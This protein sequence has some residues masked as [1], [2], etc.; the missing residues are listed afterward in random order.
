[1]AHSLAHQA[2]ANLKRMSQLSLRAIASDQATSN[3]KPTTLYVVVCAE[4]RDDSDIYMF[5]IDKCYTT[6]EQANARVDLL[7]QCNVHERRTNEEKITTIDHASDG[8]TVKWQ[9]YRSRARF[10]ASVNKVILTGNVN[11][12]TS[13]DTSQGPGSD[14]SISTS[15]LFATDDLD[16]DAHI[17]IVVVHTPVFA[18]HGIPVSRPY[19]HQ[20]HRSG[21]ILRSKESKESSLAAMKQR[22]SVPD[23]RL[24]AEQ[25]T[26]GTGWVVDSIHVDS[27]KALARAK[28]IWSEQ[29]R[30]QGPYKKAREHYGFARYGFRPAHF[31]KEAHGYEDCAQIRVERVGVLPVDDK[32]EYHDAPCP[33]NNK[34]FIAPLRT[35]NG[36]LIS[37]TDGYRT[38]FIDDMERIA[39][40]WF[41]SEE[42]TRA[43]EGE[44]KDP[45]L[46]SAKFEKLD[47]ALGH[48]DDMGSRERRSASAA[49]PDPR[50]RDAAVA[51]DDVVEEAEMRALEMPARMLRR[52]PSRAQLR[53]V[54]LS[55]PRKDSVMG[56]EMPVLR[57]AALMMVK[58]EPFG[59]LWF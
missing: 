38:S 39:D 26:I 27:D 40:D 44:R 13:G 37:T 22:S 23:V 18:R 4:M 24:A 12:K 42:V 30:D 55:A 11:N 7:V 54:E 20:D 6:V 35:I 57:V 29:F 19:S 21:V 50:A 2:V 31:A 28:K 3:T 51:G 14:L 1:M 10:I 36:E 5:S 43:S 56:L 33:D 46:T 8:K 17:W 58:P 16:L 32:P 52:K 15:H 47:D 59:G 25:R 49:L 53:P 45:E 9:R 48:G 34:L 41:S